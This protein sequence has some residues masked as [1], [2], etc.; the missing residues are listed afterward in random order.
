MYPG[1]RKNHSRA[2]SQI[3]GQRR[4]CRD[5]EDEVAHPSAVRY[6]GEVNFKQQSFQ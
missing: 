6:A 2:V 1:I 4:D 3:P 5:R